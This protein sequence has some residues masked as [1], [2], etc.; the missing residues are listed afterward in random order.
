MRHYAA[1][2]H[3]GETSDPNL[4]LLLGFNNEVSAFSTDTHYNIDVANQ[5]GHNTEFKV[6]FER[7]GD[8]INTFK[9]NF[10]QGT[11]EPLD[12][13]ALVDPAVD[14]FFEFV[15]MDGSSFCAGHTSYDKFTVIPEPGTIGLL[16][17]GGLLMT[18]RR[19][20]ARA[21]D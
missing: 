13:Y 12:T 9:W 4:A 19:R 5:L 20:K 8:T 11:Y 15:V 2:F 10:S 17:G 1:V 6:K 16:A 14:L 7:L 18:P 3:A 21:H